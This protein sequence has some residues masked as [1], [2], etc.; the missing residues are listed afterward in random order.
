MM[1]QNIC[2]QSLSLVRAANYICS[3][4]AIITYSLIANEK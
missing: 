4:K 1:N 2:D 3:P